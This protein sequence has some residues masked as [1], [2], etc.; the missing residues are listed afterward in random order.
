MQLKKQIYMQK[1]QNYKIE[2]QKK[3]IRLDIS[4]KVDEEE[5]KAISVLIFVS[6]FIV[7]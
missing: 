1:E 3:K 5:R 7:L 4:A 2:R 6:F